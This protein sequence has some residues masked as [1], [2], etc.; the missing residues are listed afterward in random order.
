M[1]ERGR[2][3]HTVAAYR[4]DL[5]RYVRFCR[6][7]GRLGPGEVQRADVEE[8][9]AALVTGASARPGGGDVDDVGDRGAHRP[10]APASVARAL[11]AVRAWHD[12]LLQEGVVTADPAAEVRAPHRPE[13]LP[14][15]LTLA[16]V[17]VLL[18]AA[19]ADE[20]SDPLALRDR[21][22]LE[23]LY[24]TGARISE[25][26]SLDV[27][28]L[29]D[30]PAAGQLPVLLLCGKGDKERIAPMGSVAQR[31]LAAYMVRGRP[32]LA[33]RGPFTP[34]VF[35][36]ARGARMSRQNAFAVLRRTAKVAGIDGV[37][38]HVL[39]H[40]FATHLLEGGADVRVVQELLGH[41][42]VTTTQIYTRVTP[43][44]LIGEYRAAHPRARL[45][46]GTPDG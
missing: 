28:D 45:S 30:D 33:A 12:F 46:P 14:K 9:L 23:L 19:A 16:Q 6:D 4:R 27:D 36:N 31:A 35:V 18:A 24:A 1:V 34:A 43:Q 42:S 11:A 21:A 17:E 3:P 20:T 37:S 2:S 25:L 7:R 22:L 40:S 39:R 10:L 5:A 32:D 26:L 44:R 29:P 15:A 41:A 38:P 13:R 8:F